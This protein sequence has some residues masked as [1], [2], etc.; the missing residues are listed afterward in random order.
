MSETREPIRN[1]EF[2]KWARESGLALYLAWEQ[3][4]GYIDPET[5]KAAKAF[6]AGADSGA[7]GKVAT[8]KGECK[9]CGSFLN[10]CGH[11]K[12]RVYFNEAD[13]DGMSQAHCSMCE[14]K[15]VMPNAGN[16][17]LRPEPTGAVAGDAPSR[18]NQTSAP[19]ERCDFNMS[20]GGFVSNIECDL[21]K[22]HDGQHSRTIYSTTAPSRNQETSAAQ[23]R[24][25]HPSNE[26][27]K[28]DYM[29]AHDTRGELM[30]ALKDCTNCIAALLADI[31][32]KPEASEEWVNGVAA[33][34]K[35]GQK[36]TA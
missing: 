17:D 2:E 9:S 24:S 20:A 8:N 14:K 15:G 35:A 4:R 28:W 16:M 23:L 29:R 10:S 36:E 13:A 34:E 5:W 11:S 30:K 3:G 12:D 31:N 25:L 7:S 32:M 19:R 27:W 21:P 1:E 26:N 18:E 6:N 33:L 22:G